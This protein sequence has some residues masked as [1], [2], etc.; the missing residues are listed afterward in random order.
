L[1]LLAG[2]TPYSLHDCKSALMFG[3]SARRRLAS[4][5]P[6]ST[7]KWRRAR[8][9]AF[10]ACRAAGETAVVE[11]SGKPSEPAPFPSALFYLG[12]DMGKFYRHFCAFGEVEGSPRGQKIVE[13]QWTLANSGIG[14]TGISPRDGALQR[15]EVR[16]RGDDDEAQRQR[17]QLPLVLTSCAPVRR[18]PF[19]ENR[20]S[21]R[22]FQP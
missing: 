13:R 14:L 17:R 6:E 18:P 5:W 12:R 3:L 7:V 2:G 1:A 10:A 15:P 9:F 11:V 21:A 22:G 4:S 19:L 8:R 16:I 20:C